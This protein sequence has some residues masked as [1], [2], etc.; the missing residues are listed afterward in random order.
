MLSENRCDLEKCHVFSGVSCF[1]HFVV[2]PNSLMVPVSGI[3]FFD[4]GADLSNHFVSGPGSGV[5]LCV[6]K[7]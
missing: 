2:L 7:K 3:N 5:K 1:W 4:S 6:L